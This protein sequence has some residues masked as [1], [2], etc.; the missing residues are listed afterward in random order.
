MAENTTKFL[1]KKRT[2]RPGGGVRKRKAS[3]DKS[4]S[5]DE[6]RVIRKEKK[7]NVANPLIQRSKNRGSKI[8]AEEQSSSDDSEGDLR[9]AYKSRR[10]GEREGPRDMGA[11]ATIQFETEKD[12]DAQAIFERSL[13]VN[14]ETK[15]QADDKIYRG[16]NN[17]TQFFEKKDTAQGNA[18]SGGVRKGPMR[19]PD[20]L[21][22]T[23]RWDYQPD[24][25][26][27]YKETGFCG[28]GDSCKFLHD[29]TDYKLGWQLEAE[30]NAKAGND[31]DENW[32]IPSDDE[33]LP[34]KCF[35]C[36]ESYTD[37]IV[38]K[39]QHYF[40]EKCALE[41]FKK[42]KRCYVCGQNTGGIFNPATNIMARLNKE[43]DSD[44]D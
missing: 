10:T 22:A 37:P 19:A 17:Y 41:Q 14:K 16:L 44:S 28:F 9:A 15:G 11:T 4:S 20:H 21:R 33:H 32:E 43:D 38:T 18:A 39:C 30:G 42:T 24:L 36:R 2:S 31:S 40:C 1:F 7:V 6:T 29:R 26:K 27:D 12:R 3:S 13:Q 8:N 35:I 23:V 5:E 25:C 34:F